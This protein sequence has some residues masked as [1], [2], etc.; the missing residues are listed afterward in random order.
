MDFVNNIVRTYGTDFLSIA[1]AWIVSITL[2]AALI[3]YL[4]KH[5]HKRTMPLKTVFILMFLGGTAMYCAFY[6]RELMQAVE[7]IRV[8]GHSKN[9]TFEWAASENA[10]WFYIPY[11]IVK[12]VI[13]VGMMFYGRGNNS[14]FYSMP[15]SKSPLAVFLFWLI[16][17]IAFYTAASALIIRFGSELLRWIRIT[18][19]RVSNVNLIF[20]INPDSLALGRNIAA[21]DD[22]I[23]IF[24][25]SALNE[26]YEA[27]IQDLGGIAYSSH[28]ALKATTSFIHDIHLK[29]GQTNFRLY[30]VSD[31][32]DKNMQYARDVSAS[33]EEMGVPP[34]QTKLVLL[35][36][37]EWKGMFFYSSE[38]QY[39]YGSVESFYDFDLS[40]R[41]LIH[42][43]PLC[44]AI[45]FD[46]NGL[47]SEDL[48]VLIV[49]FGRIGHEVLRK[50]VA[51][52][53]FEGSSFRVAVYDPQFEKRT[54][55]FMS[56]YRTMFN[57]YN[58][59]FYA[60]EGRGTEM[61]KFVEDNAPKLKYIVICLDNRDTAR[62]IAVQMIDRLHTLGYSQNVYTCDTKSVRCYSQYAKECETHW[63]YDSDLLYSGE[64]D[65]YA[66]EL[67]HRYV[68]GK[69]RN[70]DW[71]NCPYF[72]RMSSRA[73]VD[74]LMPLISKIKADKDELT[75]EQR[76]NLA[77]S[78]HLRWC[79][80][81]YTSGF[82][83]MERDEFIG[84]IKAWQ[85]EMREKGVSRIKLTK[86]LKTRKH[87]CLVDWDELDEISEL[88]NSFTLGSRD[89]KEL[90]RANIDMVVELMKNA[91]QEKP[92]GK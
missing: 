41:L 79:A 44:N 26:N 63:I 91:E 14:I 2:F 37:E 16:Q 48:T 25:D 60:H 3:I 74:Y 4:A 56:Q 23:V 1:A 12:S 92:N 36:I 43:Y 86:D 87:V 57:K 88:E 9:A 17:L 89:Y 6:Y 32:Y 42:L 39:G 81:H 10:S 21:L 29:P 30:A 55:F 31:E 33:L 61:F 90:D 40:A 68:G 66:I 58:I 8:N 80:F 19:S 54:G 45:K 70:E 67:N 22:N 49:G 72:D 50:V 64:L 51:S 5:P 7:Y 52:G 34:E 28:D 62:D 65:K 47:A 82:K 13:E 11:V 24:V 84:R 15:E 53:Q 73:S 85:E 38:T 35:G 71:K 75:Q 83:V 59:G 76:E 78:E 27:S 69:D 20:G 46:E 18:T 77:K